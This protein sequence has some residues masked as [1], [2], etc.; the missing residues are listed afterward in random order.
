MKRIINLSLGLL[1]F[2]VLSIWQI[3][4]DVRLATIFSDN[5]VLQQQ[6]EV[7]VWGW[8]RPNTNIS[9]SGSWNKK[10]YSAKSDATGYWKIKI[11]TPA[12]SY[13]PYT[14]TVSDGKAVGLKNIL[15][16]E[17]WLC[18]GQSNMEMPMKG[19]NNQPVE[20]GPDAIAYS[21][22][23]G[24]RCF[25]VKQV[26]T[27]IPQDDCEGTWDIAG[28]ETTPNFTATG[29]FFG[30]LLNNALDVP[31]GLIHCSWGGSRIEAW[32][33]PLSLKDIPGKE[34][35]QTEA[36]IKIP[37]Q[38]PTV[39][40]NGMLYPLIGFG[41]RGAIW[42][43]GES[44]REEPI[45]YV[46][47]FERMVH[48]WRNLWGLGE[49]PFYYCQI[50]PYNYGDRINS[51]YIREA[52]AKGMEITNTGMAVLM[53]ADSPDCIHPPKKKEAGE[54]LALWA[55]ANTYGMKKIHY[56]SPEV[57]SFETEGRVAVI[58]FDYTGI[59]GLTS[60]GKEI[61]NFMIAGANKHFYP[62]KAALTSD[63]VY[64]FSPYV[65]QPIAVRYCFDDTS[66]TEIFTVEGN[67]PLSSFR[68]D[69]W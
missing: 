35:P 36:D 53:D 38:D 19:Y 18:S 14:L 31:V 20:G 42:Y 44:N 63:K 65:S 16:G 29:Y 43:Q 32:M 64:L 37:S 62:A 15:I 22:N 39:L 41:M 68:T 4:A 47:K 34:I 55:L 3:K 59:N 30:R 46:K 33:T 2:A 28:P 1:L 10:S 69:N 5:M 51:A 52:Q 17:V 21:Q 23:K 67:L 58:T 26:S 8:A 50:A 56:R 6:S 13:T 57:K 12:A 27:T 45:I 9:V 60:Y 48:E 25:T 54:R 7:A 49:F 40:Y 61:K 24:I 11:Q 66:A